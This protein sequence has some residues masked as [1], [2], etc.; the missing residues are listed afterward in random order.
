[1]TLENTSSERIAQLVEKQRA[2]FATGT[3]EIGLESL[4]ELQK[5][6]NFMQSN[7]KARL[8]I[9]VLY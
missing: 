1:M 5:I 4:A 7:P 3:T 9:Q 6:A 2:F 8:I